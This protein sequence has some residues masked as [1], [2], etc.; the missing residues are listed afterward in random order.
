MVNKMI[1]LPIDLYDKLREE[2]NA[3][4]LVQNL[5][6]E[7][8]NKEGNP[9]DKLK[10]VNKEIEI[11]IKEADELKEKV[12]DIQINKEIAKTEIII[13]KEKQQ[14]KTE[15]EKLNDLRIHQREAFNNWVIPKEEIDA[16]FEEY[17]NLLMNERV[18]NIIEFM[19]SKGIFRK[20]T[21]EYNGI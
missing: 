15:E 16:L 14:K 9:A 17:F 4:Q 6:I 19:N 10:E 12:E 1:S 8:Y 20:V 21:K 7:H 11:K 3:S 2:H 18:K 5:L 13:D